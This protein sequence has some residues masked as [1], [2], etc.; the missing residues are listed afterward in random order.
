[1]AAKIPSKIRVTH[2]WLKPL[3]DYLDKLGGVDLG[4]SGLGSVPRGAQYGVSVP[5]TQ[6]SNAT[7]VLGFYGSTGIS[8]GTAAGATAGSTGS[9]GVYFHR[10][11][12][13]TGTNFYTL[14]DVIAYM[15]SRGDLAA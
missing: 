3:F 1:M 11:N 13:G 7:G 9:S 2:Q 15:K 4:S 12:G 14:D 5:I 8:Q 10:T 6:V